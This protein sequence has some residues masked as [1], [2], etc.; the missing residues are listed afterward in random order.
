MNQVTVAVQQNI[1]VV[2]ILHLDEIA[3]QTVRGTALNEIFL[4]HAERFR[5]RRTK[6][7]FKVLEKRQLALLLHL[8]ERH[9]VQDWLDQAA[10]IG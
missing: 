9:C 2:T 6:L 3:D 7:P 4:R 8:M 10:V 5:G 1:S